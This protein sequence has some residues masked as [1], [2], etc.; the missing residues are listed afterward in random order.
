MKMRNSVVLLLL[1]A[2]NVA[3]AGQDGGARAG[4][5]TTPQPSFYSPFGDF[6]VELDTF[7]YGLFLS[8]T[9]EATDPVDINNVPLESLGDGDNAYDWL[10]QN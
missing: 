8:Q 2:S 3:F 4:R 9:H 1:L 5:D 6:F 10:L 7:I